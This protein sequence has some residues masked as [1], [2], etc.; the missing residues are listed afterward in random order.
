MPYVSWLTRGSHSLGGAADCASFSS[1]VVGGAAQVPASCPRCL[2]REPLHVCA[3]TTKTVDMRQQSRQPL[4]CSSNSRTR[5]QLIVRLPCLSCIHQFSVFNLTTQT[6]WVG[7]RATAT[8]QIY[9]NSV[10]DRCLSTSL[11]DGDHTSWHIRVR[12]GASISVIV[13]R[14][15]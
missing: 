5:D 8:A 7:V 2:C 14:C 6:L 10:S 11:V 1:S 13:A 15:R 12:V 4:G 3:A 9:V